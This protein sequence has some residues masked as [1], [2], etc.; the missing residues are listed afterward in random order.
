MITIKNC[1]DIF[2]TSQRRGM[3]CY[4]H[5]A[6]KIVDCQ[7]FRV[8]GVGHLYLRLM[9]PGGRVFEKISPEDIQGISCDA[10]DLD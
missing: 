8:I 4:A 5:T 2:N 6:H 9:T 1:R 7:Y 10:Y 3:N